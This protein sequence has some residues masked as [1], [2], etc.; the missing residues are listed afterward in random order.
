MS[1]LKNRSC[2]DKVC[3]QFLLANVN[4]IVRVV[5]EEAGVHVYGV[6]SCDPFH[7]FISLREYVQVI[8]KINYL[9]KVFAGE[10][11]LV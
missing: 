8:R 1:A 6:K 9:G 7:A 5:H 11:Y 2:F 10:G 4:D 3:L